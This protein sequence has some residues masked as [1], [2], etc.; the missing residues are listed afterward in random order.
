MI[1]EI[2]QQRVGGVNACFRRLLW[3]GLEAVFCRR[4]GHRIDEPLGS[5]HCGVLATEVSKKVL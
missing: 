5:P 1:V 4:V 3:R 2:H